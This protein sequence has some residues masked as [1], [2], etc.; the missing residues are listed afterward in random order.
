[1]TDGGLIR[2]GKPEPWKAI[3][4]QIGHTKPFRAPDRDGGRQKQN[5]GRP[6]D[7]SKELL[8][9]SET[10]S[11]TKSFSAGNENVKVA[12]L[13][14]AS[15]PWHKNSCWLDTSLE[16]IYVTVARDFPS[17]SSLSQH[18]LPE[19]AL[20]VLFESLEL[21]HTMEANPRDQDVTDSLWLQRDSFRKFLWK[22]RI[23]TGTPVEYQPLFVH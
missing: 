18:L 17:F 4:Q 10:K 8:S 12:S 2:Y 15:Y 9:G 16:L 23:T 13:R 7:T 14:H 5:D 21:R 19:M 6:P 20:R 22:T 3:A 1:M 11:P